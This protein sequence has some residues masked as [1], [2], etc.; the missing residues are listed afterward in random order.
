MAEIIVTFWVRFYFFTESQLLL[1][2]SQ[3]LTVTFFIQ[4]NHRYNNFIRRRIKSH[5]FW[6]IVL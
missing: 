1:S 4:K 2:L 5:Q 6:V 3:V